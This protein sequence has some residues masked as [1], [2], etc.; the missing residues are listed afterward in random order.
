MKGLFTLQV[1]IFLIPW[2]VFTGYPHGFIARIDLS[3]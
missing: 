2:Q 3:D 1:F